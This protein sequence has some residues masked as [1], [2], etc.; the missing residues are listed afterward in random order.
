MID[1]GPLGVEL[2][3]VRRRIA[4]AFDIAIVL[5]AIVAV[6]LSVA[7]AVSPRFVAAVSPDR[8]TGEG[9]H[10]F[11]LGPGF[12][13]HWPYAIPSHPDSTLGSDDVKVS[14]DGKFFGTLEPSH[15]KIRQLGG[16]RFNFWEGG[17]WFSSSDSTD[18]RTNG[19]TYGVRVKARLAPSA[20]VARTWSLS[21]L[22]VLVL[23]RTTAALFAYAAR[24]FARM[25]DRWALASHSRAG[26]AS[27]R[28]RADTWIPPMVRFA[29]RV[30]LTFGRT[31]A[32]VSAVLLAIFCWQSLARP[33]PLMFEI[34]S[35]GYVQPGILWDAGLD[36]TGGSSR[37]LGY[38][39]LTVLAL[40]LGSLSTIPLLQLFI[41]VTG[42][43]CVLGVLYLMLAGVAS[44]LNGVS[45]IP[46]WILTLCACTVAA[47]YSML[48]VS[49]DLF[50]VDIYS[51]MAEAPHFLPT[52]LALLLF[53]GGWTASTPA[54]RVGL[55]VMAVTAAYLSIMVK[56]HTSMVLVLCVAGLLAVGLWEFR[57]FRSP[58]ILAVCAVSAGLIVEVH[59]LD[60]WVTPPHADFG[61]KTLFCNHLDVVEP[62]FDRSTPER[63]RIMELLRGVLQNPNRWP[64]M[65]YNGDLCVYDTAFTD[66]INAAAKSEGVPAASWQQRE[67]LHA[68]LKNP[69]AFG[70]DVFRQLDYFMVH[71]VDDVEYTGKGGITDD[72][73]ERFKPFLN[74][75]RM[76]HDQFQV[77]VSN[78]VPTAYP[79]LASLAKYLLRS[80]SATF[81]GVTL[82]STA[83]ALTV[84]LFLRGKTDLRLEIAIV[85]TA[86]FTAAFAMT[87]AIAHTFDVGRYLTDILPFSLL[88]WVMGIAYMAHG[89]VLLGT[90]A[91]R[92][93]RR[94]SGAGSVGLSTAATRER[95]A[96]AV[97]PAGALDSA[98]LV[99]GRSAG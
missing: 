48:M 90:L 84:I 89:L 93:D 83:L 86:A 61:P 35:N 69:V 65:G 98:P 26:L 97:R 36:V 59:R 15:D 60:A 88:W 64:L 72:V 37:D 62:V 51:A 16:G 23:C 50:V 11:A 33:M 82:A 6:G 96:D 87:T 25:I 42:L 99:P 8:V 46:M 27:L 30:P 56:P 14:E 41:V 3:D 38:P 40:R 22:V 44:R 76:S 45:H 77:D 52:A 21:I 80:I 95:A 58:L 73:W 79:R 67:F 20:A 55:L 34:D 68:V 28:Q 17:L 57:A 85:A 5:L 70:R 18:P 54:H 43:A 29:R 47:A 91:V 10:A 53:V 81:A 49:H 12:K 74:I 63:A 2:D 13:T 9:G 78:W 31:F 7:A 32:L 4:R 75:I 24:T 66:A 1:D 19:R 92:R 71:P 94:S 39:A